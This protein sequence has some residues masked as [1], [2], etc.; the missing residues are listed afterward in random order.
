M[1]RIIPLLFII[2]LT[3]FFYLANIQNTYWFA[4]DS[5]RDTL[6]ALEILQGHKITLIGPPLSFGIRGIREIYFG[7]LSYY[8]GVLGLTITRKSVF[9]PVLVNVFIMAIS[10]PFFYALAKQYLKNELKAIFA[11]CI[12]AFSPLIVNQM[13]FYWNPNFVISIAPIFWFLY[14]KISN[15]KGSLQ[16]YRAMFIYANIAGIIGGLLINLHY[17]V[18]P[19]ILFILPFLYKKNKKVCA[20]YIVG[21]VVGSLPLIIFEMRNHWYLTQALF[22]NLQN[23]GSFTGLEKLPLSI[24]IL[25]SFRILPIIIGLDHDVIPIPTLFTFSYGARILIGVIFFIFLA[26][27]VMKKKVKLQK[28]FIVYILTSLCIT[29]LFSQEDLYIRYFFICLPLLI[30]LFVQIISNYKLLSGLTMA[31]ILIV[32]VKVILFQPHSLNK[33]GAFP[34]VQQM[35]DAANIIKQDNPSVPYN[36]TENFIGDARATYLRYFLEKD[37]EIPKPN[38]ETEYTNLNVLY[39]YAPYEDIIYKEQRWEYT[40]TPMKLEKVFILGTDKYIFKFSHK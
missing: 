33:N 35:Q 8:F 2:C 21:L 36:I 1:R 22:Y 37:S 25:N 16:N 39:D 4:G 18:A 17:F 3:T 29:L 13:R 20:M 26:Y 6:K 15:D 40:A 12:F 19:V 34:T 31:Y 32:S 24:K 10:L 38:S 28:D 27:I 5:A 11:V 7:S 23:S 14:N 30:L 9:G